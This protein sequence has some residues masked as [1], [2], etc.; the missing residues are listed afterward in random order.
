MPRGGCSGL[1]GIWSYGCC[2][3]LVR[4]NV[5]LEIVVGF[6]V[7]RATPFIS[8]CHRTF[9]FA[10]DL[11]DRIW[12]VQSPG[13]LEVQAGIAEEYL[14]LIL[15]TGDESWAVASRERSRSLHPALKAAPSYPSSSLATSHP[16]W[17]AMPSS[18]VHQ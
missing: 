16:S 1:R 11:G 18:S 7:L 15:H 9:D 12:E 17:S 14:R 4:P 10:R 13:E 8:Q 5:G 6:R 3:L 2:I